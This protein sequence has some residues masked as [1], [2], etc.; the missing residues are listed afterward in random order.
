MKKQSQ[1]PTIDVKHKEIQVL[2]ASLLQQLSLAMDQT[3]N[4][5]DKTNKNMHKM[6]NDLSNKI[7]IKIQEIK[8]PVITLTTSTGQNMVKIGKKKK[9]HLSVRI[10][11]DNPDLPDFW[12]KNYDYL[13][14]TYMNLD[15]VKKI[16]D[17]PKKR[18]PRL[19]KRVK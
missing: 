14:S 19:S 7:K 1:N 9:P 3:K 15:K 16:T 11:E 6:F 13:E 8:G 17:K 2:I 4:D 12:R 10:K 5:I 18:K